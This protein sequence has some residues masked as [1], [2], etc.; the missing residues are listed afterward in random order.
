MTEKSVDSSRLFRGRPNRKNDIERD[1][2]ISLKID[3]EVLDT[4]ELYRKYFLIAKK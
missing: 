4:E 3:L 2:V 1:D